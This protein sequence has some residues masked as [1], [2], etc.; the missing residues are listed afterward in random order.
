MSVESKSN[1]QS[2]KKSQILQ[3]AQTYFEIMF[4]KRRPEPKKTELRPTP[5]TEP[6]TPFEP[7]ET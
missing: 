3:I 1:I 4:G 7:K 2:R 5:L 6:R